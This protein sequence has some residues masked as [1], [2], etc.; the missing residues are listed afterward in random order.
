LDQS[1]LFRADTESEQ[2]LSLSPGD[3]PTGVYVA[4]DGNCVD[5]LNSKADGSFGSIEIGDHLAIAVG[6]TELV[7]SD[8][9][10]GVVTRY[11]DYVHYAFTKTSKNIQIFEFSG[12]GS[13]LVC[14][15]VAE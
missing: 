12:W 13:H 6:S 2:R 1:D 4:T 5:F 15:L 9:R 14:N 8:A 3:T 7:V 10:T 11:D